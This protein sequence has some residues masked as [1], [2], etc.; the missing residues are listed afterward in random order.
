MHYCTHSVTGDSV[1]ARRI[2]VLVKY[3]LRSNVK[4]I[5]FSRVNLMYPLKW[6]LGKLVTT[7]FHL[8]TLLCLLVSHNMR[9]ITKHNSLLFLLFFMRIPFYIHTI[10]Y[11]IW[12][13]LFSHFNILFVTW[14]TLNKYLTAFYP[15]L[16]RFKLVLII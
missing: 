5:V 3:W 4:N 14:K 13:C 9:F 10:M 2:N 11:S 1:I 12:W 8:K 15:I 16:I 6:R 7:P